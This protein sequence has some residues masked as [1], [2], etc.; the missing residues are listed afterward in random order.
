MVRDPKTGHFLPG[1]PGGPGRGRRSKEEQYLRALTMRVS[2][3]DWSEIIDKAVVDAKFG[4]DK[5]R[6]WLSDYLIGKPTEYV[7]ADVTSGG[8]VIA[9]REVVAVLPPE[10][11][12]E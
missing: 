6:R 12:G 7:Q 1:N 8:Q 2:L 10:A 11:D 3:E 5:A 4:D 9:F